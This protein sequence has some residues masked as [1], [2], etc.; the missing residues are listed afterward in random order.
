MAAPAAAFAG[1]GES[2]VPKGAINSLLS[3]FKKFDGFSTVNILGLHVVEYDG[4][5]AGV[6][7]DFNSRMTRLLSDAELLMEAKDE[8]DTVR[9]YGEISEDGNKAKN[10]VVFVP[11]D[12]TLI[13]IFRSIPLKM[14]MGAINDID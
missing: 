12:Y 13:C 7:A 9:I 3:E 4:C 6:R 2:A 14:L 11:E 10:C 5:D 8:E 1:I